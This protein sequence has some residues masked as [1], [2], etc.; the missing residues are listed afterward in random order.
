MSAVIGFK[1]D[2]LLKPLEKYKASDILSKLWGKN[3]LK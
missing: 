3:L 1:L 2:P